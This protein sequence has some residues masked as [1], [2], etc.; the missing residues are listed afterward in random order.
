MLEGSVILRSRILTILAAT[1][2]SGPALAWACSA[3]SRVLT[4]HGLAMLAGFAAAGLFALSM[5]LM[6]RL[7]WLDR[8]FHGL[9]NVYQAH[10][11]LGVAAFLLLLVHPLA[12][13]LGALLVQPAVALHLLWPNPS[14]GV[15]FSGWLAL[16]LFMVFFAVTIMSRMP[17]D[18]W[19]QLHRASG[20]AYGVMVWHL[21]AAWSGSVAAGLGLGLIVAGALGYAHRLFAQDP[22][23][24]GLRYRV[25][26]VQHRGPNVVDLVLEPLGETLRFDAGQFVYLALRNSPSYRSCGQ[27]HPYTMT[28]RP[29]EP[30]LHLSIKGLGDCTRHIQE[31]TAGT[32]AR[33]QGPFG[34]LFPARAQ[35]RPQVW[36]G[37]GIGVTPFLSR[38][39]TVL[40]GEPCI[41]IIY[42][43]PNEGMALYLDDFRALARDHSNIR[44]HTIFEDSDGRPTVPAIESRVGSL[45]GK[46]LVLAGPPAMVRALRRELRAAGV[47]ASRIHSEKEVLR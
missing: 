9:G 23:W 37:G 2:A 1:L 3:G 32:E 39:K 13:A 45:E 43:A 16:L 46:E 41:D 29:D 19:R 18:L 22:A 25:A 42:A 24:R 6:L 12:L 31:V 11:A 8:A 30:R 34:G 5:L 28:G 4:W 26:E 35:H 10:H 17:F 7:T 38:A 47:P 14:S 44:V 21:I 15:V 33:I 40:P 27:F 20:L 36:L